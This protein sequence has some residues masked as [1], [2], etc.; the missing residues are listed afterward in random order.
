MKLVKY[1]IIFLV[2]KFGALAIGNWLMADGPQ[3]AWYLSLNKAPWTPP[4]WV[5]G[6]AWFSIMLCFSFYMAYLCKI[7]LTAKVIGLFSIQFILNV[8]WN[9][10]FFNQYLIGVGLVTITGL[11]MV[12]AFFIN[13]YRKPM[14]L[15]T[16]LILPYF[17][18][19]CIATSLNVYILIH[20]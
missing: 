14:K 9:Y 1:L 19:L 5:F 20:N 3:K 15:K 18:W 17:I 12:I 13:D 10:V 6:M 16:F 11:T 8:S 2:I 7:I 4:G